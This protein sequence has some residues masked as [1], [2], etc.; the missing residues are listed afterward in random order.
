MSAMPRGEKDDGPAVGAGPARGPDGREH[1]ALS[2]PEAARR[3]GAH[4]EPEG[5]GPAGAR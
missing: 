1:G 5:R 2:A 3:T 4:G